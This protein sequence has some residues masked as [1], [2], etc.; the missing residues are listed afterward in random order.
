MVASIG[1]AALS[2]PGVATTP[3]SGLET[4]ITRYQ[5]QLSECVNCASAKTPEGKAAIETISNKIGSAQARI[6]E[7]NAARL[8]NQPSLINKPSGAIENNDSVAYKPSNGASQA[9]ALAPAL[10]NTT[11]GSRI[12]ILA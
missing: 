4:Q 9:V 11:A 6:E 2:S 8:V 3:T 5:K 10:T 7:I 1:S 12:N